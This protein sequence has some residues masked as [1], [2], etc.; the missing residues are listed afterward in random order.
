M[1]EV[2]RERS[3]LWTPELDKLLRKW[4]KQIEGRGGGHNSLARVNE[5]KHYLLGIP[6]T[7]MAAISTAGI[8]STF[9][10]CNP[11]DGV[12]VR[13]WARFSF[14]IITAITACLGG[15]QTFMNYQEGA[16]KNKVA[17]DEYGSLA[18]SIETVLLFPGD[19]RGDP[20][21]IIS[22][23]R[24][25]YDQIIRKSPTLPKKYDVELT[26]NVVTK[27][28][29]LPPRP[30]SVVI[31]VADAQ[32][33]KNELRKIIEDDSSTDTHEY[34]EQVLARENDYDTDDEDREVSITLDLDTTPPYIQNDGDEDNRRHLQRLY[35][36]ELNRLNGHIPGGHNIH[37]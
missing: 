15:L 6:V 32:E 23:F 20:K 31:N 28:K 16:E 18:R 11:D 3:K 19:T 37:D 22:D 34:L 36:Y 5:R 10:D 25:K 33:S 2:L 9:Q 30:E 12:C 1:E 21:K 35:E 29:L 4:K 27:D 7:C 24:E 17:S 13:E 8:F 14:G 26:Y